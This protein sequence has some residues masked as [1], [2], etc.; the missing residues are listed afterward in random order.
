M[1]KV[2]VIIVNYNNYNDTIECVKSLKKVNY[3]NFHIVIVDNNSSNDSV[4]KLKKALSTCRIIELNE[5]LGFAGGN[6]EGIKYAL[7]SGAE[8]VLLL[9]ND[10]LVKSDFLINM[11]SEFEDDLV[12]MVGSKIMYYSDKNR[13][14]FGGGKIDWFK[15][16]GVNIGMKEVDSKCY[17]N[18]CEVDFISGCCMLIKSSVFK[19]V[20]LLPEEY[21]MYYEDVDFCVKVR[22]SGFKLI[23][24]PSS[25]I[26]HKVSIS[27]GGENS[28]FSIKFMTRNKLV[29]MKKYHNEVSNLVYGFAILYYYF[30]RIFRIIGYLCRN[31]YDKALAIKQG[32]FEKDILKL[33][34][35]K[36]E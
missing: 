5:N 1:K 6:N 13:I 21:F 30:S 9:N 29:F 2:Y 32:I 36:N 10:T 12:G 23:Y 31:H 26:Y 7:D 15:F 20:G 28:I 4:K 27:S 19:V 11:M 18:R 35:N 8:Y 14:W 17:N 3:T 25:V 24:Q 22:K 16:I 33:K 34:R